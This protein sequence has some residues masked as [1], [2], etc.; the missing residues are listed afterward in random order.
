MFISSRLA[1]GARREGGFTL[2]ELLITI[3]ILGVIVV[4]L[5]TALTAFLR[6][7]DTT[8]RRV[9]ESHDAQIS[10]AYF[11]QDVASVGDR[12]PSSDALLQSVWTAP[13]PQFTACGTGT[14]I[15]GFAWDDF[16]S[17]TVSTQ[18][19]VVYA[20]VVTSA[21]RQLHRMVCLGASTTASTDLVLVHNVDP[22]TAPTVTCSTSCSGAGDAV[23]QSVTLVLSIRN[24]ANP[25][26]ALQVTLTGQRRQ[27]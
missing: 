4:P 14:L 13:S 19:R 25:T 7:T 27:T 16:T 9:G 15:V 26:A 21:E 18:V 2:I 12:D 23:P 22:T 11:A 20:I 3:T 24:P 6:N 5:G 8:I 10:A 1:W 17:A